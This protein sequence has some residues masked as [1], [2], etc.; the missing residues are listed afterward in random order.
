MKKLLI[1]LLFTFQGL[2]F[3]QTINKGIICNSQKV[4][5]PYT[6]IVSLKKN[7]GV[8][9][10]EK[11]EFELNSIY[12]DDTIKI[13]NIAYYPMLVAVKSLEKID[14]IFLLDNIKVLEDVIVQNFGS[15]KKEQELGFI[16]FP[17]NASFNLLPGGQLAIFIENL[18]KRQ[19][20]IKEL[21]FKVKKNGSCKNSIRVRLLELDSLGIAPSFDL[22]NENVII[23]SSELKKVNHINLT[24][25]KILLPA[26]GVFV[27][28]EWVASETNCDKNV[29]TSI[30]A[31]MSIPNNLV[32]LN[33]R[34]KLWGHNNRPRLPN[35][36]YMTPNISI[37]VA[38]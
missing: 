20:W 28:L 5:L 32:W 4:P 25:Y 22:L 31:N 6:N 12:N 1:I 13:T 3:S 15:F 21:S 9:T 19:A 38:Y 11:G 17:N 26:D 30:S 2:V 18:A 33:F 34:D 36:N 27:V 7:I 16:N 24:N 10:N 35:G 37:K 23:N 8:S 14:T 29:F